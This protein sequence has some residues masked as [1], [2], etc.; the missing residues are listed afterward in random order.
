MCG[1]GWK[2]PRPS[3]PNEYRTSLCQLVRQG[4]IFVVL[5]ILNF[6]LQH[7]GSG[8]EGTLPIM[9]KQNG[10]LGNLFPQWNLDNRAMLEGLLCHS[11]REEGQAKIVLYH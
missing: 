1:I 11:L 3:E 8:T 7:T 5:A 2:Q 4:D 6:L 9:D 10:S